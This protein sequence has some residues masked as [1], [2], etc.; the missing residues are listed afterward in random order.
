M[1]ALLRSFCGSLNTNWCIIN[2]PPHT[3]MRKRKFKNIESRYNR[4]RVTHVS[5]TFRLRYLLRELFVRV[6]VLKGC[7]RDYIV[8]APRWQ[9]PTLASSTASRRAIA[10]TS[11]KHARRLFL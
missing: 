7:G 4:Q 10:L 8:S 9:I 6:D 1:T 5:A 3:L 11:P 2:A